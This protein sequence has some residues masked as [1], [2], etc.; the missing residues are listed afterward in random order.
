MSMRLIYISDHR[1]LRTY[2]C[3]TRVT[4]ELQ[5]FYVSESFFLEGSYVVC[6]QGNRSW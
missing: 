2:I 3:N 5:T 1:R 6:V 4:E